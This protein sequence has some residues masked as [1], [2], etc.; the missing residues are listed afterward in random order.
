MRLPPAKEGTVMHEP[1]ITPIIH[2]NGDRK[3]TLVANLEQAYQAVMQAMDTL[4]QCAPNGRNYYP[5]P[6][7]MQQAEAQHRRRQTHLQA[8]L[9]DLVAEVAQIDAE[10]T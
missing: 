9:D 7:R 1:I 3:D 8:V 2:L 4:R 10:T 5:E 6:G